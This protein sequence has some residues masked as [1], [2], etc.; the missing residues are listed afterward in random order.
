MAVTGGFLGFETLLSQAQ[1]EVNLTVLS[2]DIGV[3]GD[4]TDNVYHVVSIPASVDTAVLSGLH[5]RYGQADAPEASDRVGAGVWNLGNATIKHS[6]ISN[7]VSV[8]AG[9]AIYS[10]GGTA[11][12]RLAMISLIDNSDPFLV[13]KSGS[14]IRWIGDGLLR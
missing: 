4:S 9:S 11:V 2:G 3:E 1:P 10:S 13:N 7:C 12:L 6:V 14:T 5:I 8:D